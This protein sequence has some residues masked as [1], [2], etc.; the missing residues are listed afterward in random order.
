MRHFRV[1]LRDCRIVSGLTV[2]H[3]RQ[4]FGRTRQRPNSPHENRA[5]GV[6]FSSGGRRTPA[7]FVF[8]EGK[9][10]G[11]RG[12]RSRHRIGRRGSIVLVDPDRCGSRIAICLLIRLPIRAV[13][14][15]PMAL[16]QGLKS[17]G[18]RVRRRIVRSRKSPA[19]SDACPG[20]CESLSIVDSHPRP[21][22]ASKNFGERQ[23]DSDC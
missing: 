12:L 20:R 7:R 19:R 14:P 9:D 5:S 15:F 3:A 21:R 13:A 8:A 23:S 6:S 11:P 4:V 17:E 22:R 1:T 10:R 2:I 16:L 18:S